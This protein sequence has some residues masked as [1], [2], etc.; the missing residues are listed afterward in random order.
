[1]P[2]AMGFETVFCPSVDKVTNKKCL[3]PPDRKSSKKD[4]LPHGGGRGSSF[5]F[6]GES[7]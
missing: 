1:M 2:L 6:E 7:P 3:A 5:L 4:I